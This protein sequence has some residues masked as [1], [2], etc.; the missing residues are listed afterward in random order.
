MQD[1]RLSASLS[2][3]A[4]ASFGMEFAVTKIELANDVR[5]LRD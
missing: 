4:G 1:F 2:I 3:E 5:I